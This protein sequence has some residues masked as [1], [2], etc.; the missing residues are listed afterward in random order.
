[1][2]Y[3]CP[4]SEL[5]SAS[6]HR[7]AGP[8][9]PFPPE[10]V[11]GAF[12]Q[13][14]KRFS[15]ELRLNGK[16]LWVH[17]NNS[18]SML[19]L[20]RPGAPVLASPAANP[21]RKLKYTQECVWLAETATPRAQAPAL[22]PFARDGKGRAREAGGSGFWVG[23]NTSVPNRMLEA[24]FVAGR[25]AFAAGYTRLAREAK[26]G[27]CRLDGCLSGPG[28][29]MLWV[30]CKNVTMV[31]DD[32]ACFPDAASRRGQK[33]LRELM[34]IVAQGARAAMFYLVQRPDG[35]C[36][37]PADFIDPAYAALFYEAASAGVEMY[38]YRAAVSPRGIELGG[39]LPV[40]GLRS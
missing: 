21:A 9:L 8:L 29:P 5:Q 31:E 6:G 14:R 35:Q 32:A 3:V 23:V 13:R 33:H 38:P 2:R 28:L 27:Q 34:D 25:L 36:F 22:E 11:I 1:M 30:E 39:L 19:G 17:S 20:T 16:Q 18:G 10:C 37:A 4:E 15:V 26:R 12:V 40:R 24:A 7:P